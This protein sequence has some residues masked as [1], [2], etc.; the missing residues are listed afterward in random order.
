M[1]TKIFIP[2]LIFTLAI[3]IL[4]GNYVFADEKID[5]KL[6]VPVLV[7][8]ALKSEVENSQDKVDETKNQ[9]SSE[10]KQPEKTEPS[11]KPDAQSQ[12]ETTPES[13]QK[14]AY[15]QQKYNFVNVRQG[16]STDFAIISKVNKG[17]PMIIIDEKDKWYRVKLENGSL[18]WVANWVVDV[19]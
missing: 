8:E 19:K 14:V 11:P 13:T 1:Q 7:T 15:V 18:G 16:P 10:E 2:M 5:G 17:E 4:L 3:G 9:G 12:A 6:P